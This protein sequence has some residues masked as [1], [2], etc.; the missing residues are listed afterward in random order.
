M[1]TIPVFP[2]PLLNSELRHTDS[3]FIE[4]KNNAFF[5]VQMHYAI[6]NM[7]NA[8][9]RCLVR[10]EVYERLLY[11]HRFIP[12]N[13][14]FLIFDAWRPFEL[15]KELYY[16]YSYEIS[17]RFCFEECNDEQKRSLINKY[18]SFP[19]ENRLLPPVHTTGGAVD[20]SVIDS[21][22]RELDMGCRFDEFGDIAH[23]AYFEGSSRISVINN[24]RLL[25]WAMIKAGFT[26]LPSEW[27]HY[28]YGDRFWGF[29]K[30]TPAIYSGCFST[31]E[32]IYEA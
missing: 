22:G 14:K 19:I 4:I 11:A 26:N 12:K 31:E 5:E 28:D 17:H 25:F 6:H 30:N 20:L 18:V 8:E 29:Y 27:W 3:K 7:H 2:A 16:K 32:I 23:T 9:Q 13:Y 1:R 21:T 15:Q 10:S 24:R